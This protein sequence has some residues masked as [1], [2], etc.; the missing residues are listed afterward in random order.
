MR[1]TKSSKKSGTLNRARTIWREL[2]HAQRRLFEIPVR[3][4]HDRGGIARSAD[5]LDHLYAA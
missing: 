2:D 3:S 4:D 1:T 5:E